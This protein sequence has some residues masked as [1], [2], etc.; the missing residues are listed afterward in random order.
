[1]REW[2]EGYGVTMTW[3][4]KVGAFREERERMLWKWQK[5]TRR[6]LTPPPCPGKSRREALTR[7]RAAGEKHIPDKEGEES[8]FREQ[9]EDVEDYVW[10]W[11]V[12]PKQHM[13]G[14]QE[15][16]NR[17]RRGDAGPH[18]DAS[19]EAGLMW[20]PGSSVTAATLWVHRHDRIR[21]HGL[22]QR[23]VGK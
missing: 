11:N 23:V 4:S 13:K 20:S 9:A 3:D 12:N 18:Q 14:F 22:K 10:W 2:L 8:S 1:M 5:E 7:G 17:V 6:S 19:Q 16:K 21:L 15:L